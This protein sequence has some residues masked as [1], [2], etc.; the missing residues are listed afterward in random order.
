MDS[1]KQLLTHSRLSTY[2]TCPRQ[3][4][5]RYVLGIRHKTK[6]QPLRMG[7]AFA[8]GKELWR[9]GYEPVDAVAE[10][11]S[12]YSDTP[13]DFV[14]PEEWQVE[15]ETVATLLAGYFWRY[16]DERIEVILSEP[17]FRMALLNPETGFPSRTFALAGR[18]DGIV[19]LAD[20]RLAILEDKLAGQSI[21]SDDYWQRLRM[22]GQISMY[23]L[24]ARYLGYDVETI[25]YDVSRKPTIRLRQKE[26]PSQYGDRLFEDIGQRPDYYYQRREIPRLES[27]LQAFLGELWQQARQMAEA[28]NRA[29]KL[30]RPEYAWY[31]NVAWNTCKY[32]EYAGPCLDGVRFDPEEPPSGFVKVEPHEELERSVEDNGENELSTATA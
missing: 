25:I 8:L 3:D 16:A 20:G 11:V 23:M 19:R 30:D 32:C 15:A 4:Y 5:Y 14:T 27:D 7:G 1:S 2:R 18:I 13:P 28:Q 9:K 26:T 21:D 22:D 10:A 6:A 24:G 29:A 31:R 17:T 12:G